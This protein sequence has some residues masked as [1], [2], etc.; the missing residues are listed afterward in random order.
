MD[1]LKLHKSVISN[2]RDYL[3][4]FINIK[5][6]RVKEYVEAKFESEG[7][8]P[9]PL[10]QFNPS[11]EKGESLNDLL[12]KGLI[13]KDLPKIIGDYELYKHQIEGIKIG[14][15]G[16][17]FVVTSGTGSGK[18]LI[19]LATIFDYILKLKEK[20]KGIKA[21]LVYPMNAL[22]NSQELEIQKYADNYPGKF[23]VTFA[24]YTGQEDLEE[25]EKIKDQ[26]PD[27]ILTNYMMLELIMTR[28]TEDWMRESMKKNLAY[29]VFDELHTYRGRQGADVAM[30]IRRIRHLAQNEVICIGTSATMAT[31]GTIEEQKNAIAQVATTIF[32]VQ[33]ENDQIIGEYL[34]PCTEKHSV[35]SR[36]KLK[37]A[38]HREI[39]TDDD[40]NEFISHPL[41]I[42]I[43]NRVAL[44]RDNNTIK[45]NKPFPISQMAG[46][47]SEETGEDHN[48]CFEV[49][50]KL[51]RWSEKLN[52]KT[53]K[54][55][56]KSFLPFKIHQ[57]ISQ[58]STVYVTLEPKNE[59]KISIQ[60]GRYTRQE[61]ADKFIYPVLFSR[62]SGHEFL[63]VRKN[64][65][66][67][68]L[69]PRE[70]EDLPYQITLEDVRGD[71]ENGNRTRV[72][73]EEDFPDGYLIIPD[74][75]E[76]DLWKDE[77]IEE[78]PQSWWSRK[79][80]QIQVKN[81]Y[82]FRIPSKI[83]FD[84]SGRYSK[85]PK[86]NQ[87]G[88]YMPAKILF[89]PTAGIIYDH[90]TKENTKL[91]RLGNEGRSSATTI[92]SFA[93]IH[94]L[95]KQK[96]PLKVQKLL[97][98]TDNRQ[99]AS[100]QS[101]HFNDFINTGRLRS[102]LYHAIADSPDK[103]LKAFEIAEKT[104][105]E[106]GLKESDYARYPNDDWPD[107][108]NERAAKIY[109]MIRILYDL[110]RGW[111]YNMPNLEQTGLLKVTYD[112]MEEFCNKNEFFKDL[113]LFKDITPDDRQ[114]IIIQVLNYFRTSYALEHQYLTSQRTEVEAFMELKL[115]PDKQWSLDKNEKIEIPV[116]LV[117]LKPG[118]TQRDIFTSS[119]GL[120]SYIGKYFKR[121][122]KEHNLETLKGENFA[123][124][125]NSLCSVLKRGNFL[126]DKE[127]KGDK[128]TVTGYRLRVDN[129]VWELGDG[130][131]VVL[132]EVRLPSYKEQKIEPNF[133][134][135]EFY[136]QNFTEFEKS[137]ISREH[138][139]QLSRED[140]IIREEEFRKGNISALYCSPT[141]ELGIDI[142]ELNIVHM[143]NVPPNPA[144][145]AQRSG[146]AGRSGQAAVIF[147]YCSIGSPHDRHYFL[148]PD[149]MVSGVVTPPRIDLVN[150][151]L[152]L[153][154]FNAYILMSLGLESI[155]LSVGDVLDTRD[156]VNLPIKQDIKVFL[157]N[158]TGKYAGVWSDSFHELLTKNISGLGKA[159][160]FNKEWLYNQAKSFLNRFDESFRRWRILYKQAEDTIQKAREGMDN[161]AIQQNSPKMIELKRQ[162]NI[163]LSQR[164][165]LLNALGQTYGSESEFY[166]FRYLAAEGF[167]PGYNFTRLPI[168]VFVGHKE[169]QQGEY[170]ARP[171]FIAL[172]EFGP[173]NIIYH[174]GNKYRISRMML[175]DV[176]LNTTKIKVSKETG[177]A[178]LREETDFY[179]NDPITLRELNSQTN[180]NFWANLIELSESE[181]IPQ[182]RIS[183]EEEERTSQ[184][185]EIEQYF[186]YPKG[187]QS[188]EQ[189]TIKAGGQPI[190]N[191]IYC[192]A[193][194]LIQVN[195]RWQRSKDAQGF[196]IDDRNGRW[197]R[198]KDLENPDINEHAR[199]VRLFTTDTADSIYIQ[200]VK[201][202]GLSKEQVVSLA[203]ALKRAIER[204]FEAE[205]D[206]IGV[207]IMGKKEEPNILI[208]EASE[209][210]LGI[211]SQL[212]SGSTPLQNIFRKAYSLL[213]F[214]PETK[215]D[216]RPDLPRASYYDLLSY[217]NQRFHDQLDRFSIKEALER[218]MECEIVPRR[219]NKDRE[220]QYQYLLQAYDKNSQTE[221]KFINYLY[222]NDFILPDRA[223]VNIPQ[224]YVNADFVYDLDSGPVLIFC[225][226]SVHDDP[227]VKESDKIKRQCLID[228]GYDIIVWYYKDTIEEVINKRRDIFRKI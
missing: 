19:F 86:Y 36:D 211:L 76:E 164:S 23:P 83:Y 157:E 49:I 142:A 79:N 28:A 24:K 194:R 50:I 190:L 197:L 119:L 103:I 43:E 71:R 218:L 167:L 102:A 92:K 80:G 166:I 12:E 127:I 201:E 133:Y 75:G 191:V 212:V 74:D 122:F 123:E 228:Q 208:Y 9:E 99:D 181:A 117:P 220:E 106:L 215:E 115:D 34:K 96:E 11:Y 207:W 1:A 116:W 192:P 98:F 137:L 138:T 53:V 121:L 105:K 72:L 140:R 149:K 60:Q 109:V 32:G 165:I 144:N 73:T 110:K 3:S 222:E 214:N 4:S 195:H 101:G 63:C 6:D 128:L 51:L 146:R 68:I 120:N 57:F 172:K 179:N 30:L 170:I 225:D 224:F 143:R 16:R 134:F 188:T 227:S 145:Y 205:E 39:N 52:S 223:Q 185:F 162:H 78:L 148:N 31:E 87:W 226:G 139:G 8:I 88:W 206:E 136:K 93:V 5:D 169:K 196:L 171:R 178:F 17:G 187:I 59:R 130:Q 48:V 64:L 61:N 180:S 38:I 69:E 203:F 44:V 77:Y 97:S 124:F 67:N 113:Y 26:E 81:F 14:A 177:Y 176:S 174:N 156:K 108:E 213:H 85:E 159:K 62:Y 22:I 158:M 25:R 175:T 202:L 141:M 198:Q 90:Q 20:S 126:A 56:Q 183:S 27:I 107:P 29:L 15:T 184:G 114:E 216:T 129:V 82:E 95:H 112:R 154:H 155:S 2:Y 94:E 58:T 182:E 55:K 40:E 84:S 219:K 70:P 131:S 21:V 209:G 41:V 89:D 54:E 45:R 160:W 210:T 168:R 200:P 13:H 100:L 193:T 47:L 147:T 42:W 104:I 33:F 35:T 132:D 204:H 7:F 10:I 199:E 18:S 135:R 153:T 189:A 125:M 217:Y 66:K 37:E 111:R 163:A 150:E 65:E 46:L 118:R 173:N 186:S 161:P 91:M 151:E 221:L 152:I